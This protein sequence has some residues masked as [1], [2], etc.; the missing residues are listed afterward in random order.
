[1]RALK[2]GETTYKGGTNPSEVNEPPANL[3]VTDLA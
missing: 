2:V 1:M 3:P